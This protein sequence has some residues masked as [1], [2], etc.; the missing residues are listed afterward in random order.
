MAVVVACVAAIASAARASAPFDGSFEATATVTEFAAGEYSREL[1]FASE[2]GAPRVWTVGT[3]RPIVLDATRPCS[4]TGAIYGLSHA[5]RIVSWGRRG[6]GGFSFWLALPSL[7]TGNFPRSANGIAMVRARAPSGEALLVGEGRG[8][9][10][11]YAVGNAVN[12]VSQHTDTGKPFRKRIIELPAPP[13][14]LSRSGTGRIAIRLAD[15]GVL[16]LNESFPEIRRTYHYGPGVVRAAKLYGSRLVILRDGRLD[17][18]DA[19]PA[20]TRTLRLPRARSYGDGFCGRPPCARAELRLE[21]LHRD[22]VVYVLG[23][24]IHILRLTDGKD[25]VVRT[26]DEGPVEAQ[27]EGNG[28]S[29]SAGRAISF[30]PMP[31]VTKLLN[32]R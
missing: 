4:E 6:A 30:L 32:E 26:P 25:V 13:L 8:N 28:L 1:A 24:Q 21:D 7:D 17:W 15:G 16:I 10:V 23:R 9:A 31:Q 20:P 19:V 22:L 14:W 12:L 11:P 3:L 29:Y 27:I 2:C 5:G 18:Y